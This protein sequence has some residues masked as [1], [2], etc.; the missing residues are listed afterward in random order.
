MIRKP[1][2]ARLKFN[3]PPTAG[4]DTLWGQAQ[5]YPLGYLAQRNDLDAV[6][7]TDPVPDNSPAPS[8]EEI[9]DKMADK[10]FSALEKRFVS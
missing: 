10:F 2:E 4:G 1:D 5:D 7:V 9:E 6:S 3:D 8:E